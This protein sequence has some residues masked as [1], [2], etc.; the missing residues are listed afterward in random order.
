[1][2]G[3]SSA[4]GSR[5]AC[6]ARRTPGVGDARLAQTPPLR[7]ANDYAVRKINSPTPAQGDQLGWIGIANGGDLDRDGKD[8]LLVP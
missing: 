8:D 6:S 4:L 5:L 1:M 2:F 3:E 7:L